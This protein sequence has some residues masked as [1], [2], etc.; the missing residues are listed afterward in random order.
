V[1]SLTVVLISM[2]EM[3]MTVFSFDY[4]TELEF[5]FPERRKSLV[6]SA[7]SSEDK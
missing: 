6:D 2:T 3:A 5:A 1:F 4:S 7:I